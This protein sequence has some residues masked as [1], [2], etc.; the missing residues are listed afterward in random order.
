MATTLGT[1]ASTTRANKPKQSRC[2]QDQEMRRSSG[3]SGL[4]EYGT[5]TGGA[6]AKERGSPAS[7]G[8]RAAFAG[9]LEVG[10]A[11]GSGSESWSGRFEKLYS[12]R[13][14]VILRGESFGSL[15]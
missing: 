15:A 14:I 3:T 5:T 10:V 11:A 1:T 12:E 8:A 6:E 13:L 7:G 2:T 9:E 4:C